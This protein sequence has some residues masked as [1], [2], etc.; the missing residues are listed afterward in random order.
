MAINA[1]A[2]LKY[3]EGLLK[4]SGEIQH[5]N[6]AGRAYYAAFHCC[7]P[8]AKRLGPQPPKKRITHHEIIRI[9]TGFLGGPDEETAQKVR[10]LGPQYKQ[11]RDLR[12][13]ADYDIELDFTAG[14]AQLLLL[15]A[16]KIQARTEE[17]R[18]YEFG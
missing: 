18:D 7:R 15:T 5:R 2:L 14:D 17:L 1:E 11:I 4:G 12:N 13:K 10:G 8:L 9:I 6:S 3:A 16:K